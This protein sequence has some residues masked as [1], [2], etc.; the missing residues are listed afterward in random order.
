[1]KHTDELPE[2]WEVRYTDV[3]EFDLNSIHD[4]I[5][6]ILNEPAIADKLSNKIMNA[7][8]TLDHQPLRYRLYDKEPW[9]SSG[10]RVMTVKNYSVFYVPL[11]EKGVVWIIRIMYNRRDFSLHLKNPNEYDL[12]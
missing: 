5:A 11:E 4:Y 8:D 3:A 1:M 9:Q 6:E 2:N 7:V 12:E 10:L